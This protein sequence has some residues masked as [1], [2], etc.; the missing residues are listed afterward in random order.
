MSG[1][2][3]RNDQKPHTPS[4]NVGMKLAPFSPPVWYCIPIRRV[5]V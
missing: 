2:E 1:A 5:I 3:L 4:Q